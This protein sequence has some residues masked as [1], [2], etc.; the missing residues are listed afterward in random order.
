MNLKLIKAMT[1]HL[2]SILMAAVVLPSTAVAEVQMQVERVA[3]FKNGYACVHMSGKLEEGSTQQITGMPVPIFGS[4][5]WQSPAA[6]TRIES[7]EQPVQK[8]QYNIDNEELLL[9]N[10]GKKV[11]IALYDDKAEILTGIILLPPKNETSDEQ[12]FISPL[13]REYSSSNVA[14][15]PD[16]LE[17]FQLRQDDGSILNLSVCG[18]KMLTI[19]AEEQPQLPTEEVNVRELKI[20]LEKPAQG[21]ELH[22]GCLTKGLSWLPMYSLNLLDNRQAQ[23]TCKAMILNDVVDIDNKA[24]E[25]VTGFPA[26]GE[27]LVPS[28]LSISTSLR[29]F[30]QSI[31]AL[32]QGEIAEPNAPSALARNMAFRSKRIA[33]DEASSDATLTQAADLFYYTLPNF[34]CKKGETI[35]RQIFEHTIPCKHVYTCYVPNQST[36]RNRSKTGTP[37]ADVWH[38]VRLTNTG[39]IPWSTGTVSCYT[40]KRLIARS[41]LNTTITGQDTLIRLNKTFDATVNCREEQPQHQ[42]HKSAK[43]RETDEYHGTLEFTNESDHEM[44]LEL[45]KAIIGAPTQASDDGQ[46]HITPV[47]KG[48]AHSTIEWKL[49]IAPGETKKITYSYTFDN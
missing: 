1:H 34:S 44:D 32:M 29:T 39:N 22:L 33:S 35:V 7:I 49:R 5:W 6:I 31:G 21:E 36:L 23:L 19:D 8:P 17:M 11:H 47:Y 27:A 13:F 46:I 45:V 41:T 12:T 43:N 18:I 26:L 2:F 9:A 4:F 14:S 42:R 37:L 16:K 15:K 3:L 48:N 30:L 38:C 28:P 25:L 20:V 40:H 24:L 10:E